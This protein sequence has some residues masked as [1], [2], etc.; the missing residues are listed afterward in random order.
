LRR[1]QSIL[2][3]TIKGAIV[4]AILERIFLTTNSN[5]L[6]VRRGVRCAAVRSK[7]SLT[8]RC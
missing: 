6:E 7:T 2:E 1:A 8:S 5:W 4:L 3:E